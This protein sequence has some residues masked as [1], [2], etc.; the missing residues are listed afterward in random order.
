[1]KVAG[2]IVFFVEATMRAVTA[3]TRSIGSIV[4][5]AALG[6]AHP[7][8]AQLGVGTS[9]VRTDANGAG[10]VMTVEACCHG[11]LRLVYQAPP[12]G[13][14]PATTMSVDS[15]MDGTEA[16]AI[17]GGKPSGETMAI[18]RVDDRHYSAV[19]KMNGAQIATYNATVS[20]D[21]KTLT[22][23]SV[24]KAGGKDQT[25]VETWVRK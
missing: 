8:Y 24:S 21:T 25:I 12:M 2:R 15:P 19:L 1:V 9:W 5:L 6:W 4:F 3:T 20:A 22:V 16:P 7:A 17:M 10:I 18:K 13:G 14:Q 11:G 23:T